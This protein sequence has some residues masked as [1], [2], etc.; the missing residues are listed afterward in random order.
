MPPT[1]QHQAS[2]RLVAY[3][4]SHYYL[5][6]IY[7]ALA[8]ITLSLVQCKRYSAGGSGADAREGGDSH[9]KVL[10]QKFESID[11][12][13]EEA[14][15][16]QKWP[17]KEDETVLGN[18]SG[19]S[20]ERKREA[21]WDEIIREQGIEAFAE[22]VE[23]LSR[24]L[25]ILKEEMERN[26]AGAFS[27]PQVRRAY[28]EKLTQVS[29]A[30][31]EHARAK[32]KLL[33]LVIEGRDENGRGYELLRFENGR[34]VYRGTNN[35]DAAISNAANLVGK[36]TVYDLTGAGL[37]VG[38][39][40]ERS[41]RSS[42]Q[43]FGGRSTQVDGG[44]TDFSFHQ[45]HVSGTIGAS[46]VN[47]RA[48]G[49]ATEVELRNHNWDNDLAEMA[50][51]AAVN[52]SDLSMLP[53]SN[54]SYGLL[55]GW[56]YSSFSGNTGYH[57][58]GDFNMNEDADFG[59]YKSDAR[60]V[61][62]ICI[63]STYYL[64]VWAAGNDRNDGPLAGSTVYYWN[65]IGWSQTTYDP[66]IHPDAESSLQY[67]TI[68]GSAVA[69]NILTVGA[70]S[71]AVVS[72]ERNISVAAMSSF[73][74]WGPT[75]DGR[76][77]P[78]IVANGVSLFSCD[79]LRN[80]AY[81]TL[82][83]T[84]MATPSVTGA[85]VLIQER[86]AEQFE[87]EFMLASM[88][89]AL[90]IHTAD[91]LGQPGPDY[92]NGWGLMNTKA[93]V[94]LIDAQYNTPS[95]EYLIT[96]T[97]DDVNSTQLHSLIWDQS[98]ELMKI[99][100]CWTDPAGEV[101]DGV[102][103]SSSP[104]LVND[105]DI[106]IQTPS[107]SILRPW[108][109]D[110]NAPANPAQQGDNTV[111]NVEQIIIS[112]PEPG[113]YI[114][115]VSHKGNITG[116]GQ[117]Y[118]MVVTGQAQAAVGV[119]PSTAQNSKAIYGQL[120]TPSQ[121]LLRVLNSTDSDVSWTVACDA[122]WLDVSVLSG[123]APAEGESEIEV[124]VNEES[125]ALP[126]GSYTATLTFSGA[127]LE[128]SF[129]RF[130]QLHVLAPVPP[131]EMFVVGDGFDLKNT[132][133]TFLPA[134]GG[135][136]VFRK[137]TEDF[138][139]DPTVGGEMLNPAP[140]TFG[141]LDD[142]FWTRTLSSPFDFYGQTVASINIGTNGL[143]RFGG[144]AWDYTE[145]VSEHFSFRG[146]A[147][148]WD[149]LNPSS[150][151][152]VHYQDFPGVKLVITYLNV[153]EYGSSMGNSAQ[154]EIFTDGTG[155]IRMT[156][157]EVSSVDSIVGLSDGQGTPADWPNSEYN[158]NQAH[159]Y[160]QLSLEMVGD[161]LKE[162]DGS[163]VGITASLAVS[164]PVPISFP[165]KILGT[166]GLEDL[167][168]LP[169]ALEFGVFTPT[170]TYHVQA[171]DEYLLE[172]TELMEIQINSHPLNS[173]QTS[174]G[175]TIH[176]ASF[177]P[178]PVASWKLN[179][180][181]DLDDA[182]DSSGNGYTASSS[183]GG[184]LS[185]AG[186]NG[187]GRYMDGIE[188]CFTFP[189]IGDVGNKVTLSGW[190]RRD[191]GQSNGTGILFYRQGSQIYGLHIGSHSDLSYKWK[192]EDS[193][194]GWSSGLILPDQEWV[195][196]AMVI[197]PESATIYMHDGE[198]MQS[199]QHLASHSHAIWSGVGHLGCDPVANRHFRGTLDECR[200]YLDALS[201]RDIHFLYRESLSS[202]EQYAYDSGVGTQSIAANEDPDE[203]GLPNLMELALA[204][205]PNRPDNPLQFEL[206]DGKMKLNFNAVNED[207]VLV[208]GEWS[209]DMV[210]WY[211][212]GFVVTEEGLEIP[213]DTDSKF[214]R[215]KATELNP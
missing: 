137:I 70:V 93:A 121:H 215:I 214:V 13:S 49:M 159:G 164:P 142:G 195:L 102:L 114:L 74:G 101:A 165:L 148:L 1:P 181:S 209:T 95:N 174:L 171:V 149:D 22:E 172:N 152:S 10:P 139:V 40:D 105:L 158:F 42:H 37:R 213:V 112:D 68:G 11:L 123:I 77:K 94:D 54:H 21:K 62:N 207:L 191:G 186:K 39:W 129:Q 138:P 122:S 19:D 202:V 111:D 55:F 168:G 130:I 188:G 47:S 116:N 170:L 210:T 9:L 153:P 44:G 115:T 179:E 110:K 140:T 88:L 100:L 150:A 212:T 12:V 79:S 184:L 157:L 205:D 126:V 119:F 34:P 46:G 151:G 16:P 17:E 52:S 156:F 208:E 183:N 32:A 64:P 136:A 182:V 132:Q 201:D 82:S 78:D 135:Y 154:L 167:S 87:G 177:L 83:G 50:T 113:E 117:V 51:E 89:K 14:E 53:L 133:L 141:S 76:V 160:P 92:S 120:A 91:D 75:D 30:E 185:V 6:L 169:S 124:K 199:A 27:D 20:D 25:D 144:E 146:I 194:Q 84:S 71:D 109:L 161:T 65:G 15:D 60:E 180:T 3:H 143:V 196:V 98:S 28:A 204:T 127:A 81:T 73:S 134:A 26:Q 193:E 197:R 189:A 61:D 5:R 63:A 163:A 125:L 96:G 35:E 155:I 59:K 7:A 57:F 128:S 198:S 103:D 206:E 56:E 108:I 173:N 41:V 29:R 72:G 192:T 80:N 200:I 175:L 38:V 97:L 48:Q 104:V 24:E 33:G 166:A 211:T 31:K 118:S 107:G 178:A 18:K 36:G 131:T 86:Y 187:R 190:I 2:K 69:K 8:V 176:D 145:S 147:L 58:V 66:A 203:D 67:D 106:R 162:G 43:E 99:T 85:A 90:I 4:I 45:T 23:K